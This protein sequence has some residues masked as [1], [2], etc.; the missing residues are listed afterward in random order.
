[1]IA[2]INHLAHSMNKFNDLIGQAGLKGDFDVAMTY[3]NALKNQVYPGAP[4]LS[5]QFS[6]EKDYKIQLTEELLK[7]VS[8]H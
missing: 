3:M 2:N 7:K 1:M 6:M 8:E 5:N 4:I